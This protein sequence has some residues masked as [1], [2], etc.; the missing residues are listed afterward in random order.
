MEKIMVYQNIACGNIHETFADMMEEARELYDLDDPTNIFGWRE[1]Y[2]VI[3][4]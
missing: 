3:F 4:I 2:K 1:Y